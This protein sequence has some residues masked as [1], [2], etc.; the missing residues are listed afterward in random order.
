MR[1]LVSQTLPDTSLIN[2][3]VEGGGWGLVEPLVNGRDALLLNCGQAPNQAV[4]RA[5]EA[6]GALTQT[7][8]QALTVGHLRMRVISGPN[9]T[10]GRRTSH[11]L[12]NADIHQGLQLC[13]LFC[14]SLQAYQR[15]LKRRRKN[16]LRI[17]ETI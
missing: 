1:T 10:H 14:R 15:N 5:Q 9:S 17:V 6:H 11:C 2:F 7:P 4:G 8:F 13:E 12:V 3:A 16:V